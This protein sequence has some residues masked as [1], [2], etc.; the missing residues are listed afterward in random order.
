VKPGLTEEF[1]DKVQGLRPIEVEVPWD[2]TGK[3][4]EKLKETLRDQYRNFVKSVELPR[5]AEII[6]AVWHP[7]EMGAF[8]NPNEVDAADKAIVEWHKE[9]QEYLQDTRFDWKREPRQL[10]STL[11]ILYAQED[12]WVLETLINIIHK[13]NQDADA[14]HNAV[15]KEIKYLKIG[16]DAVGLSGQVTPLLAAT[17]TTGAP[18]APA[19]IA[20]LA[21]QPINVPGANMVILRDPAE[22]RYVDDKYQPVP[23]N[24]LRDAFKSKDPKD[25]SLAVAKRMPV[26]MHLVVDQRYV[27]RLL[28]ECGNSNLIVEIRQIRVNRPVYEGGNVPGA[29]VGRGPAGYPGPGGGERGFGPSDP[30]RAGPRPTGPRPTGPRTNPGRGGGQGGSNEEEKA[31]HQIE[32]ELY[33]IV[34]IYNPVNE[35]MVTVVGDGSVAPTLP[36]PSPA[37]APVVAPMPAPAPAPIPMPVEPAPMP[38]MNDTPMPVEPAPMPPMNGAAPAVP[39]ANNTPMNPAPPPA[40]P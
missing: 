21:P 18:T 26:R 11:Q 25:A 14:R 3:T 37:P 17:P 15:V 19:P 30:G 39:P 13:T 8:V 28:A 27:N 12:L 35:A 29:P 1:V 4:P 9:N 5:L 10:P 38:P 23:P 31:R 7:N 20:P 24:R 2:S 32:M 36:T 6:G 34:Y 33:G 40:T 22:G 16:T